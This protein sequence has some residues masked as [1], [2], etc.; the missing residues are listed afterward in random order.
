MVPSHLP[1]APSTDPHHPQP[2]TGQSCINEKQDS[3]A[4]FDPPVP[5]QLISASKGLS[6]STLTCSPSPPSPP[7]C[8]AKLSCPSAV[9]GSQAGPSRVCTDLP[10]AQRAEEDK[11]GTGRAGLAVTSPAL[12]NP[13]AHPA[14]EE[15]ADQTP[16][17]SRGY[18]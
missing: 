15:L 9:P 17:K 11:P 1:G 3:F 14:M 13:T 2:H 16:F 12:P 6:W 8:A 10:G 5:P 18:L 7:P 4:R